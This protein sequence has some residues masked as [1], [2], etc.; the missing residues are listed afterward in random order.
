MQLRW[1]PDASFVAYT[2]THADEEVSEFIKKRAIWG[3]V[4][5]VAVTVVAVGL[6]PP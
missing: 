3:M 2:K 5:G 1:A 6:H 4:A